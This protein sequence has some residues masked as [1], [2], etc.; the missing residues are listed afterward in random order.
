MTQNRPNRAPYSQQYSTQ[1]IWTTRTGSY[2]FMN[3]HISLYENV[4]ALLCGF[5]DFEENRI[6][7][8]WL[9]FVTITLKVEVLINKS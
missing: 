4:Y 6:I 3:S 7:Y 5:F 9:D 2:H 8:E 1:R